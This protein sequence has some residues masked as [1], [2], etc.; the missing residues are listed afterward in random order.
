M[1]KAYQYRWIK[2]SPGTTGD[3]RYPDSKLLVII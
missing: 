1:R 3:D 2:K